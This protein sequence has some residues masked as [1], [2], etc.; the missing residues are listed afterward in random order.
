[1]VF[2]QI[3]IDSDDKNGS[4]FSL[5]MRGKASIKILSIETYGAK[6]HDFLQLRSDILILP[7]STKPFLTWFVEPQYMH[8]IDSSSSGQAHFNNIDMNGKMFIQVEEL[9]GTKPNN[10]KC[11]INMSVEKLNE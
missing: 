10:L 2:A 6:Q 3:V 11:V 1:M 7:N 9:D 8:N 4:Y 5:P